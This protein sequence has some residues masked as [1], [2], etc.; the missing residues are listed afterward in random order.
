MNHFLLDVSYQQLF[1]QRFIIRETV[2]FVGNYSFMFNQMIRT[3]IFTSSVE[4]IGY[5]SFYNCSNLRFIHF[6]SNYKLKTIGNCSFCQSGIE[7][8]EIP[9]SIEEIGECAFSKCENLRSATFCKDPNLKTIRLC[10]FYKSGIKSI[11][12]PPGVEEIKSNAF[13]KCKYLRS[14]E[15]RDKQKIRFG[16]D[17]F[18]NYPLLTVRGH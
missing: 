4:G 11:E 5:L 17:V 3:V 8:I 1:R 9:S 15:Y 6:K 10:S 14:V 12:I 18:Y 16:R 7:T 2:R 13:S